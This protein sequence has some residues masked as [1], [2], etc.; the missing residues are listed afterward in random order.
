MEYYD[1]DESGQDNPDKLQKN[2]SN[3][4]HSPKQTNTMAMASMI[5]SIFGTLS[6]CCCVAFPVSIF[7]GVAA[8][9]LSILSKKGKPFSGYAIAG[10]IL[11]TLSLI[12]GIAEGAYMILINFMLRDPEIASIFDQ[13]LQQYGVSPMQ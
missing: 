12:L 13:L 2:D 7:L 11:G 5:C 6:L 4:T 3:L 10:L 9:L 8:I 1:D